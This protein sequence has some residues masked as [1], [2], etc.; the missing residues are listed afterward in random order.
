MIFEQEMNNSTEMYYCEPRSGTA[1]VLDCGVNH[2]IEYN[3]SS[4]PDH[5]PSCVS[6]PTLY[7]TEPTGMQFVLVMFC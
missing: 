2:K 3:V 6:E 1:T 7:P 5:D 4:F